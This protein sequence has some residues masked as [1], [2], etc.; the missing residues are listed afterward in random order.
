MTW[1]VGALGF[2]FGALLAGV[3]LLLRQGRLRAETA[4]A[5]AR[6]SSL[7]TQLDVALTDRDESREAA[8]AERAARAEVERSLAASEERIRA[9]EDAEKRLTDTFRAAGAEALEKNANQFM[10]QA[11]LTLEKVLADAKG[12][13]TKRQEAIDHL[14][15]PIRES[16]DRQDRAVR[17]IEKERQKAYSGLEAQIGAMMQSNRRLDTQTNRLVNALSR[18][19]QRGRWGEVQLRNAVELAGMTEHCDF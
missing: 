14:V 16:L 6:A 8:G 17:E 7:G 15:R 5:R 11:R 18:P 9:L 1:I 3:L 13:V 19:T 4:D 10:H 2:A 12:D